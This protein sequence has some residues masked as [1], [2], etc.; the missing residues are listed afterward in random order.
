MIRLITAFLS[1]FLS[2]VIADPDPAISFGARLLDPISTGTWTANTTGSQHVGIRRESFAFQ[3]RQL[4]VS[5]WYPATR[6]DNAVPFTNAG[7]LVGEAV[8]DAPLDSSYGPHGYIVAS[9]K[10]LDAT[11]A[12]AKANPLALLKAKEYQEEQNGSYAVWL[13][14]S[15]WFRTTHQ[16]LKYRPQEI[17]FVIDKAIQAALDESYPFHGNIDTEN[18]GMAG[19]SLGG[20]YTLLVGAGMAEQNLLNPILTEVNFCAWPESR[21]FSS[22]TDLHDSRI[23]AAISLAPPVFIKPSEKTRGANSIKKPLMILTGNDPYY[24]STLEPQ[25]QIYDGA[26]G[27]K[28]KVELN[29]IN[30]M[31]IAD[32]YQYN[33]ELTANVPAYLKNNVS[34]KADVYM[35]YSSAF[36]DM[37]LKKDDSKKEVLQT[38]YSSLVA[39]FD[40]LE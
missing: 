37:Y 38:S 14:Y 21:N 9:I 27:P 25:R 8:H 28:H 26:A 16:G 31:L 39:A 3:D 30:H 17:G 29:A 34:I 36:F 33:D 7:G 22:P 35:A 4:N 6:E 11:K 19:H 1:L 24:E 15:W 12:E 13:T 20:F 18:I 40:Y 10:H 32:T 23:K 5:W 2:L